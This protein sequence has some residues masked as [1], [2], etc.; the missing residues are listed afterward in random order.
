[1]SRGRGSAWPAAQVGLDA[2]EHALLVGDEPRDF[3]PA[4]LTVAIVV[5]LEERADP[6][7]RVDPHD[8]VAATD[9]GVSAPLYENVV[10]PLVDRELHDHV[11]PGAHRPDLGEPE[12]PF[13]LLALFELLAVQRRTCTVDVAARE[14]DDGTFELVTDRS[15]APIHLTATSVDLSVD[16]VPELETLAFRVR[17]VLGSATSPWSAA[18]SSST[19]RTK[20]FP[21]WAIT[22]SKLTLFLT[23]ITRSASLGLRPAATRSKGEALQAFS[24]LPK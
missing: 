18:T 16:G 22:S 24:A 8:F 17:A 6:A 20:C 21:A 15:G 3:P 4:G 5:A 14:G 19:M 23:W 12:R 10:C 1:M 7:G 9:D 11:L 2:V 13:S